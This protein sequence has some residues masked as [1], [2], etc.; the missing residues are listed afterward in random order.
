VPKPVD[1]GGRQCSDPPVI[2]EASRDGTRRA[3]RREPA[4]HWLGLYHTFE[5]GCFGPGD[6][7]P[8]TP[9]E[10]EPAFECKAD[11]TRDSCKTKAGRDPIHNF[12]DYTEDFCMNRFTSGQIT[13]MSNTW[14]QLRAPT[15]D[16]SAELH[17]GRP[18][19]SSL[20]ADP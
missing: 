15:P 5:G 6:Y 16:M 3:H 14:Q 20:E 2:A 4:G 10:A 7:V 9:Y 8:D 12:M 13:R 1:T 19:S 11:A 17:T 18:V